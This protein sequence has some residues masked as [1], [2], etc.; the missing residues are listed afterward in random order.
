M[1]LANA[2]GGGMCPDCCHN[3]MVGASVIPIVKVWGDLCTVCGS[4]SIFLCGGE[5]GGGGRGRTEIDFM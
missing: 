3:A 4:Q 5:G 1:L 2:L